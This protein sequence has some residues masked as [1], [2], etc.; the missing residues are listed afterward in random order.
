MAILITALAADQ[1]MSLDQESFTS[2]PDRCR[3]GP[4]WVWNDEMEQSDL[5]DQIEAIATAGWGAF[6]IHSR[7]GLTV[8]YLSD[9][10][11]AK[12]EHSID[13]AADVG[14]DPWLYDEHLWPSGFADGEIPSMGADYRIKFLLLRD[15]PKQNDDVL[16]I[17]ERGEEV[18]YL[19]QAS[20]GP[21]EYATASGDAY[22]DL[23]N[24]DVVTEFIRNT[25]DKY[26]EAVGEH[27]GDVIP[28]VF[29]DEPQI[30]FPGQMGDDVRAAVPWTVGLPTL[31]RDEHDYDVL[32]HLSSL[33]FA[34]DTN[35][36]DYRTVRYDFWR[37]I[38]ERFVEN[39]TAR[40]ADWCDSHDLQLTGHYLLEDTVANQIP[41]AGA[42]MPHYEHEH[43]PGIDFL[44]RFVG[45]NGTPL[46]AKQASSAARQFDR[47]AMSELYGCSGQQFPFEARKWLGDWHLVHG[48]TFLNH[49]LSLHSMR[50]E[51]KRDYPPNI[52][53]QQPWWEYNERIA[54]YFARAVYALREGSAYADT[55]VVHPLQTGWINHNGRTETADIS[56]SAGQADGPVAKLDEKLAALVE[57]LLGE[58]VHFDLGDE[59]LLEQYASI[60]DGNLSVGEMAYSTVVVPYCQ[61]LQSSTIDLLVEFVDAGGD[62][63]IV[64]D[65][66][67]L[68]DG[69]PTQNENLDHLSA[70][71]TH[72]NG[73]DAVVPHTSRPVRILD[74]DT[75]RPVSD[76][77]LHVRELDDGIAV[78]AAN[79]SS[80]TDH[81]TAFRFAGEGGRYRVGPLDGRR[82]TRRDTNPRRRDTPGRRHSPIR[83]GPGDVHSRDIES[84]RRRVVDDASPG[85]GESGRGLVGD[86]AQSERPRHRR[87]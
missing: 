44:G 71:A 2:P 47:I 61:T 56:G 75:Q 83:I 22:T 81:A 60:S 26:A 13:I 59:L 34:A 27:F 62:V 54:E 78:F 5:T 24:P 64:G 28:G 48:I 87:V 9:E 33:F 46:A 32:D 17:V 50:G 23:L 70:T 77:R 67:T 58:H 16:D 76:V 30:G 25:H 11:L 6:F 12:V 55:L 7:Y 35:G 41:A 79:T 69:R 31:F 65:E 19:C 45:G 3:G 66:P 8:D 21:V 42:V 40:L 57:D 73:A 43:M 4:F 82:P 38:T 1:R 72:V 84:S 39:F 15:E 20:L 49:H 53:Y 52:F 14:L 80:E 85:R 10:W 74:G 18:L 29:T 51:R 63:V 68:V 86:S 36:Q 37:L